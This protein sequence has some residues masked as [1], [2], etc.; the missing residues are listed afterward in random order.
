M[1]DDVRICELTHPAYTTWEW[2]CRKHAVA[3]RA[4]MQRGM[5][6]WLKVTSGAKVDERCADCELERQARDGVDGS[7]ARRTHRAGHWEPD[8]VARYVDHGKMVETTIGRLG[9]TQGAG[10]GLTQMALATRV[11]SRREILPQGR[12]PPGTT[13]SPGSRTN[14]RG[15]A[16]RSAG[17]P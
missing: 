15:S 5:P 1:A 6:V 13:A 16:A 12:T 10:N 4:Q 8:R 11:D 7:A 17:T 2:L 9:G 3:R 14:A